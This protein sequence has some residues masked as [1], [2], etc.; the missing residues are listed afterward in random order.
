MITQLKPNAMDFPSPHQDFVSYARYLSGLA[1]KSLE[2]QDAGSFQAWYRKAW[3]VQATAGVELVLMSDP[4]RTWFQRLVAPSPA[5]SF[6]DYSKAS[7]LLVR[8]PRWPIRRLLLL[9]LGHKQDQALIDWGLRLSEISQAVIAVVALT[10]PVPEMYAGLKQAGQD[11]A[12]LMRTDTAL[13]NS[14]RI[15]FRSLQQAGAPAEFCVQPGVWNWAASAVQ[16]S[17]ACDLIAIAGPSCGRFR[18]WLEGDPVR[19]LLKAARRPVLV[20]KPAAQRPC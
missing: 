10:P 11:W 6:V 12:S 14:M 20:A 1:V 2:I 15:A 17:A 16:W 8:N 7:V 5:L 18:Q 4:P 3:V 19:S 9:L 13:G